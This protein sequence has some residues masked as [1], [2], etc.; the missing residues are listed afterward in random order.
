[1]PAINTLFFAFCTFVKDESLLFFVTASIA[2]EIASLENPFRLDRDTWFYLKIVLLNVSIDFC[3]W[4]WC[5]VSS[6]NP[7]SKEITNLWFDDDSFIVYMLAYF[8]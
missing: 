4:K 3:L 1:M 5:I 2:N 6:P 7:T 8:D